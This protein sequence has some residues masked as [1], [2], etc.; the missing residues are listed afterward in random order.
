MILLAGALN[1]RVEESQ[2][3]E[4]DLIFH[5]C[6]LFLSGL[7]PLE[8]TMTTTTRVLGVAVF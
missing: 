8:V 6:I 4:A 7:I 1:E 5:K 2:A 3:L